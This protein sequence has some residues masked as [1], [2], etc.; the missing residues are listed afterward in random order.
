M[1]AL[2]ERLKYLKARVPGVV[3]L[4]LGRLL[5]LSAGKLQSTVAEAALVLVRS[6]EIDALGENVDELTARSAMESVIGNVARA[7]RKLAKAGIESFVITA[8]HGHQFSIRK[9]D[10]M[11]TN[12]PGGNTLELHRRCWIGHG[13]STPPGT[14]RVS[15]SELGYDTDLDF[16]FPTGLGVFKAGGGLS[17]HHGS[18]S[19]QELVI[20][21]LSLRIS[22]QSSAAGAAGADLQLYGLPEA[23]TNRTFGVRL[24]LAGDLFEAAEV[25]LRVVLLA[26]GEQVGQAGM[27]IGARLDRDTGLLHVT[28]NTEASVGLML[29]RDDCTSVRVVVVDPLTDAELAQSAAVPLSL[30]M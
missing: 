2:N 27:A 11:K 13:G 6:Q 10:D 30:A 18:V 29:L 24:L 28:R 25:P 19:L 22:S 8:D 3:D 7:I 12:N 17:F 20:P 26:D 15:G 4:P 14:V 21:V 5:S 1:P 9:D 16:V 23:I